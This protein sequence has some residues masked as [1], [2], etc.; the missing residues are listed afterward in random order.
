MSDFSKLE[1]A[2]ARRE[3]RNNRRRTNTNMMVCPTTTRTPAP[4][5]VDEVSHPRTPAARWRLE[6]QADDFPDLIDMERADLMKG[7]YTDDELANAIYLHGD[8][9]PSLE[10][11]LSGK[12]FRPIVWLTAG[13]ERIRWL[14]RKLEQALS[15]L[16]LYENQKPIAYG[17]PDGNWVRAEDKEQRPDAAAFTEVFYASAKL[18]NAGE[19]SSLVSLLKDCA[20]HLKKSIDT[21]NFDNRKEMRELLH[22]IVK[23]TAKYTEN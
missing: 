1:K 4:T 9:S 7:D 10:N 22:R 5:V 13:K 19:V 6:G 11:L 16:R 20:P 14:S 21:A 15:R 12:A 23:V 3:R 2:Q 8:A 18:D 17:T